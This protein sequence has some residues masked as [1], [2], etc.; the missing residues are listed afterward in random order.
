MEPIRNPFEVVLLEK[1]ESIDLKLG[2]NILP[3]E[4]LSEI[5]T[6]LKIYIF[7]NLF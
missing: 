6:T 2:R 1:V 5:L 3:Y 4:Y 7:G